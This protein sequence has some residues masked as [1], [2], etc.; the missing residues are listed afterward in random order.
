MKKVIIFI[1]LSSSILFYACSESKTAHVEPQA[2]RKTN[3]SEGISLNKNLRPT[4]GLPDLQVYPFFQ[5]GSVTLTP[6]YYKIPISFKEQNIGTAGDVGAYADTL[7]VYQK[8][9]VFPTYTY[10]FVGNFLR[11]SHIP[12]GG[13]YHL[14]AVVSFPVKW[15][16]ADGKINLVIK[17]DGGNTIAELDETN[18]LSPTI[19]NIVLP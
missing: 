18:N 16:P 7:K 10:R 4:A 8:I 17:A 1:M 3:N 15:R 9:P 6:F 13:T 5:S 14:N 19:W 2:L 12:M 11:T